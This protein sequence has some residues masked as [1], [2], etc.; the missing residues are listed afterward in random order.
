[1]SN[2]IH[3]TLSSGE[4]TDIIIGTPGP[5]GDTG[6]VGLQG[7]AGIA[8][9]IGPVGPRGADGED[10]QNGLFSISDPEAVLSPL[11][12]I[13]FKDSQNNPKTISARQLVQQSRINYYPGAG[14]FTDL[15]A[16]ELRVLA[17]N[18]S[19][20]AT[21]TFKEPE[22]QLILK[23]NSSSTASAG[24]FIHNNSNFGGSG[25][26]MT[27]T[28]VDL[29]TTSHALYG[30]FNKT[31]GPTFHVMEVTLG[32]GGTGVVLNGLNYKY[33]CSLFSTLLT[34]IAPATV[35][36]WLRNTSPHDYLVRVIESEVDSVYI[37]NVEQSMSGATYFD[38][39]PEMG[40]THFY[41]KTIAPTGSYYNGLFG[42]VFGQ[43]AGDTLEVA[44]PFIIPGWMYD[45][46]PGA[47]KPLM[48]IS[49]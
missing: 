32:V 34:E 10:G 14:R 5:K 36:V 12:T 28:V 2:L 11:D 37:N 9:P 6:P 33:I 26:M 13:P 20:V 49:P 46:S 44:L 16:D 30:N 47:T 18:T 19:A 40:W 4:V 17:V 45:N 3:V 43:T 41:A 27:Q 7:P 31:F 1:M 22:T 23:Y 25:D 8:G 35:G 48:G 39:T 29:L 15:S 38:L 42:P 21:K 24:H